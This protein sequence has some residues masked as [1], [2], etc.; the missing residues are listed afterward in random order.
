MLSEPTGQ[1]SSGA[2][3]WRGWRRRRQSRAV[4]QTL[5]GFNLGTQIIT[6]GGTGGVAGIPNGQNGTIYLEQT[7]AMLTPTFGDAPVMHALS[8]VEGKA[9]APGSAD[10]QMATVTDGC[11]RARAGNQ[12]T[13]ISALILSELGKAA[14]ADRPQRRIFSPVDQSAIQDPKTVV[15]GIELASEQ[16]KIEN[17]K[18]KID[19]N[20]YLAMVA[21]GKIKP[22]ASTAVTSVGSGVSEISSASDNPK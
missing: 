5:N 12:L 4:Y 11:C 13:D 19:Q 17:P 2:A 9:E 10:V 14:S 20:L 1:R 7:F 3:K 16:S 15:S 18:S 22:F 21:E 6:A 8:P